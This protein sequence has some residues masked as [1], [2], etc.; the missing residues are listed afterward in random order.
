MM[1]L[2]SRAMFLAAALGCL[3]ASFEARAAS[4]CG[5]EGERACCI[6]ERSKG[7]CDSGLFEASGCKGNCKCGG[8]SLASSSSMCWKKV[9]SCGGVG[10]RA[11]CVFESS[12]GAC[13]K[14][15]H[16]E[17]GCS[18]N[19]K[20]EKSLVS[21]SGTCRK[22]DASPEKVICGAIGKEACAQIGKG[23]KEAWSVV[24]KGHEK[25]CDAVAS[26]GEG[27]LD[28]FSGGWHPGD[29]P[30]CVPEL[31]TAGCKALATQVNLAISD[32]RKGPKYVEDL[33]LK[34]FVAA[35]KPQVSSKTA[36]L[37]SKKIAKDA[38]ARL[39]D[40]NDFVGT[41]TGPVGEAV[42]NAEGVFRDLLKHEAQFEALLAPDVLC[43]PKVLAKRL[44]DMGMGLVTNYKQRET[45][46]AVNYGV[47][48]AA[49]AGYQYGFSIVWKV[50]T[51]SLKTG[52]GFAANHP[53]TPLPYL[54]DVHVFFN[55]GAQ[56]T[57]S[58]GGSFVGGE[59][60]QFAKD[61]ASFEGWGFAVA[62]SGE[63]KQLE[64]GGLPV[65][66]GAGGELDL[67]DQ[68]LPSGVAF[69]ANFGVGVAT[70]IEI[71]VSAT[72]S[73]KLF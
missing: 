43:E 22:G 14:G 52:S 62:A 59:G 29:V 56:A 42:V 20:C 23:A 6:G 7:P 60:V 5:G 49:I 26:C 12:F 58:A 73:W 25:D 18:G 27:V 28:V 50:P 57:S 32:V 72:H 69:S 3:F 34:A 19:C 33:A 64:F 1:P 40:L 4:S 41:K 17:P 35:V 30:K 68:F 24:C 71:G 36:D 48:V 16:E 9:T 11:C 15:L 39:A 54:P 66:F 38:K 31:G 51:D 44:Q 67:D 47:S 63:L 2:T 61:W 53:G 8:V 46:A 70:P 21:S 65:G 13:K 45:Y 37:A 55:L 10:E